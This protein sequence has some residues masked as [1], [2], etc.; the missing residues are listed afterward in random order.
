MVEINGPARR[1]W[2]N[3]GET[4]GVGDGCWM[5]AQSGG[6]QRPQSRPVEKCWGKVHLEW[7]F[8]VL[9]R[10]PGN[11]V[12]DSG[13]PPLPNQ[14]GLWPTTCFVDAGI[15]GIWSAINGTRHTPLEKC[16]G[17]RGCWRW[18]VDACAKWWKSTAV[19]STSGEML[20]E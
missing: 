20:G 6:N 2:R 17:N 11:I 18:L 13:C 5:L 16:W 3:A 9:A 15:M 12:V 1:V 14:D 7:E 10:S 19:E 8:V 4:E